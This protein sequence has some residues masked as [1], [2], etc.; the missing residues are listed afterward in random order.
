MKKLALLFSGQGSQ[1]SGMG[2]NFYSTYPEVKDIYNEASEVLG[3]DL[4]KLCQEGSQEEITRTENAQPAILVHSYASFKVFEKEFG[5]K[6]DFF[7][8]HSL[9]EISALTCAGAINFRDAVTIVRKRGELMRDAVVGREAA[10]IA[11]MGM[12]KDYLEELC[13][14]VSTG[15]EVAVISN[16][17]S[18]E[19]MVVSG[20]KKAIAYLSE[21]L[22]NKDAK[23]I[24]LNVSA[25]FHCP[26]MK[27]AADSF[28]Q[29]LNQFHFNDLKYPVL[30]NVSA[31]LYQSK[32]DIV[33]N[34]KQQMVKAVQWEKIMTFLKTEGTET[35][36][37]LGPKQVLKNLSSENAD[38]IKAY[39]FDYKNDRNELTERILGRKKTIEILPMLFVTRCMAHAVCT[40]NNNWD[41]E[42]YRRGV[43]DPY[44]KV[45]AMQEKLEEQGKE[46]TEEQM[47]EALE[48]LVSVFHT[49]NVTNDEQSNRLNSL[50]NETG[51]SDLFVDFK[52]M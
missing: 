8:G 41:E 14:E 20:T 3:F 1:Y 22:S 34:L 45:K 24:P 18:P 26:L 52:T 42:E 36:V 50:F 31:G 12:S 48:M 17:N 32:D 4:Y 46:P 10:M 47:R 5:I 7:A 28:A 2:E 23:V 33:E 40:K 39:G 35:T 37:E 29:F 6:P 11:V 16:Y 44:K 19:Q 38:I 21:I 30:S 49:K 9:G 15:D 51:T 25:P 13:Q 27:D 43:I